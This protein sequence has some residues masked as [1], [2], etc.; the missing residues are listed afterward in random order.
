[1]RIEFSGTAMASGYQVAWERD[2]G[3]N[4]PDIAAPNGSVRLADAGEGLHTLF[5]RGWDRNGQPT[6]ATFG[7]IGYDRTPPE[8]PPVLAPVTLKA[9]RPAPISWAPAGDAA[10]GVAGYRIYIGNDPAGAS[11][12]FTPL[13]EIETP[14]LAAGEYVLRVQPIDY[15][16]NAGEWVTVTTLVVQP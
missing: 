14:S 9:E 13:P 15:A 7:L 12:W 6:V 2:P 1:V 3:G 11:E 16:G 8:P 4:T 10:S 5:V